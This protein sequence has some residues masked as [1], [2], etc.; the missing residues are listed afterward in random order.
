MSSPDVRITAADVLNAAREN[1]KGRKA[2][3]KMNAPK[4]KRR[5]RA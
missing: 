3:T 1:S 2:L 5:A 4:R